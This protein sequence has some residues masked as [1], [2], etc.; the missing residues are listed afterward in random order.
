MGVS[1]RVPKIKAGIAR[2]QADQKDLADATAAIELFNARTSKKRGVVSW[3]T[4]G[5]A[6][7]AK[8]H[9]A[10]ILCRS[11]DTITDMDLRVKKRDAAQPVCVILSDIR[12]PRCNGHGRPLI[13]RL[14]ELPSDC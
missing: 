7:I 9:W 12:C 2:W 6:L 3:P 5:A 14:Q 11:C 1:D 10:A 8:H 13:T 4:I